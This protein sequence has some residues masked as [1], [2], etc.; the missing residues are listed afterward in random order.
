MEIVV[1]DVTNGIRSDLFQY[2]VAGDKPQ[3]GVGGNMEEND[4][5]HTSHVQRLASETLLGKGTN[6]STK[7][8][9]KREGSWGC[10]C[11]GPIYSIY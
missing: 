11:I 7:F 3:V 10:A 2:D 5:R 1:W 6:E 9:L 4:C 8:T